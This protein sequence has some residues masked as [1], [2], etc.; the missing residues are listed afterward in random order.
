MSE[1]KNTQ[2]TQWLRTYPAVRGVLVRAI[3]CADETFVTDGEAREFPAPALEQAWR[4]AADTF[5]VLSAQRFP[6]TRLTWVHERTMFHC[7]KR[8]DG[9]ILGVFLARTSTE[10]DPMAVEKL[11]TEFQ[12]LPVA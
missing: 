12:G 2:I 3:R 8:A 5:Q 1:D 6:P 4:L 11:L 7:A 10:A 9:A